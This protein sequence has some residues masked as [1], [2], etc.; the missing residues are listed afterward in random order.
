V[1]AS[2]SNVHISHSLQKCKKSAKRTTD[3]DITNSERIYRKKD[4]LQ[5]S[6]GYTNKK[7]R[8]VADPVPKHNN[9]HTNEF[10]FPYRILQGF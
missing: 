6:A 3:F 1:K 5:L 10:A 2:Q 8:A 9:E 4:I 7:S